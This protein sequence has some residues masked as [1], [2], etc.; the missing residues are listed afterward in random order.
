MKELL[1]NADKGTW[2]KHKS[3]PVRYTSR[4]FLRLMVFRE[5]SV[6]AS[7]PV[8]KKKKKLESNNNKNVTFVRS[9]LHMQQC[10]LLIKEQGL[11][12]Y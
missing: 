2:L 6:N 7:W 5:V 3:L 9:P 1:V 10:C 11:V 4:Q 12:L 8:L